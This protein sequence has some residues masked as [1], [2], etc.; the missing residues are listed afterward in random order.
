MMR[1]MMIDDDSRDQDDCDDKRTMKSI[2][3]ASSD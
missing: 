2:G 3:P 1:M